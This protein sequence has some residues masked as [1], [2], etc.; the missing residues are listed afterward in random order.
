MLKQCGPGR[1]GEGDRAGWG[2]RWEVEIGPTKD[3]EEADFASYFLL[4]PCVASALP[5]LGLYLGPY[6]APL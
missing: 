4:S 6:L 2:L 5:Y 1:D 3:M